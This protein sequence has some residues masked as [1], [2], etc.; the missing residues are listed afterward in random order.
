MITECLKILY[1]YWDEEDT[2]YSNSF[3]FL[4]QILFQ[5]FNEFPIVESIESA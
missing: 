1:E 5:Y 2:P 3:Y 4:P